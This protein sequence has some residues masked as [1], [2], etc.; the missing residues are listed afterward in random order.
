[1]PL[2]SAV[3]NQGGLPTMAVGLLGDAQRAEEIIAN[4]E[5]DF[6]AL[7][8]G[9]LDDPNWPVHTRH[10]LGQHDYDLWPRP[11]NRVRERDR[12]LHQRGFATS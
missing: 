7:A 12:S 9:A 4:G 8:R 6:I 2:A 11:L 1:M 5:A 3:R 10:E